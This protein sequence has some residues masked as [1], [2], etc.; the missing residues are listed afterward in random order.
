MRGRVLKFDQTFGFIEPA[1]ESRPLFVHFSDIATPE[2]NGFRVLYAN[3]LVSFDREETPKGAKA[4]N[5]RLL[6]SHNDTET[7]LQRTNVKHEQPRRY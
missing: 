6:S 4:V 7:K 1:D 5:V 2:N 3:D